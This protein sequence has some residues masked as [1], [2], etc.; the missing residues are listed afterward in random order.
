MAYHELL[1]FSFSTTQNTARLIQNHTSPQTSVQISFSSPIKLSNT[2]MGFGC[3]LLASVLWAPKFFSEENC[4]DGSNLIS[5][6]AAGLNGHKP[7]S[8]KPLAIVDNLIED[9][10][11]SRKTCANSYFVT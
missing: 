7:A 5:K 6:T 11:V 4:K 9:N 3:E 8:Q 10:Q 1:V 2:V